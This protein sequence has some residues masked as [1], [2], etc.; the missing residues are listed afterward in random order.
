[1]KRRNFLKLLPVGLL[2]AK[3]GGLL[4]LDKQW[5]VVK[6]TGFHIEIDGSVELPSML[7]WDDSAS[8]PLRDILDADESIRMDG[9]GYY[10]KDYPELSR[11]TYV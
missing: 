8:D 5:E 7:S 10:K 3:F 9:R 1:M 2:A 4:G 11:V 6:S